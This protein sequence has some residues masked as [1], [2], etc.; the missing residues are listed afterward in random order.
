VELCRRQLSGGDLPSQGGEPTQVV[1]VTDLATIEA[2]TGGFGELPNGTIL[3]GETV[4]RLACDAKIT[5]IVVGP[6]S[7]PLDVGR[8][9]RTAPPAQR[10]ALRLRDGGC[11]F[12]GCARPAE[13]ADVHHAKFWALGG[14]TN[15]DE[16]LLLCRKH[17]TKVHQG[18]WHIQI[19]GPGTFQF[20]D[21]NGIAHPTT[22]N[23]S[24]TDI[25]NRLLDTTGESPPGRQ[26]QVRR[27]ASRTTRAGPEGS[28]R[29]TNAA[30]S[31]V[32]GDVGSDI[33]TASQ[34]ESASDA[35]AASD[36]DAA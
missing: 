16:M 17:H 29:D 31:D 22:R 7:L 18:G 20:I 12:P 23:S 21:P 3:R 6:D 9:Q 35:E 10:K 5:R 1:V 27:P 24:T 30:G 26:G 34:A 15:I 8:T 28:N 32:R 33:G 11:V 14:Q 36:A 2:R 25:V 19:L 4:R 13:W